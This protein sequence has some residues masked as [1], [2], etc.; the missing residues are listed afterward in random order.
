MEHEALFAR[1][2][3]PGTNQVFVIRYAF[4]DLPARAQ[5]EILIR[6]VEEMARAMRDT[7]RHGASVPET[8]ARPEPGPPAHG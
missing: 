8:P 3:F 5:Q 6:M 4:S 7:M 2:P 1:I